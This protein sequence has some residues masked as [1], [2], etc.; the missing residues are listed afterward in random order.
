M[1]RISGVFN[2]Q[3][4]HCW[5]RIGIGVLFGMVGMTVARIYFA[6]DNLN[7][8]AGGAL[9]PAIPAYLIAAMAGFF[10]FKDGFRFMQSLNVSRRTIFAGQLLAL[11][12]TSVLLAAVELILVAVLQAVLP[13]PVT[14][15]AG[16]MYSIPPAPALEAVWLTA[17]CVFW[18]YLAWF[19]GLLYY[20]INKPLRVLLVVTL[21]VTP[22][23]AVSHEIISSLPNG[24]VGGVAQRV[25]MPW[26]WFYGLAGATPDP[27]LA[28][29]NFALAAI[30]F[31]GLCYLPIRRA[32]L[33]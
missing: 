27:G 16:L 2:F 4:R 13:L 3:M 19:V 24:P 17:Y 1:N 32:P 11:T 7:G 14:G 10:C 9:S 26:D 23:A 31:A 6:L 33:L 22:I 30:I 12:A 28:A 29:F 18:A 5:H 25:V 21:V 20:R 15:K 8:E